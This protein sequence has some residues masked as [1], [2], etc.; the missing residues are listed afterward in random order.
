MKTYRLVVRPDI[1]LAAHGL[2]S[3][4]TEDALTQA[5]SD[6][7]LRELSEAH[8]GGQVVD[9]ALRRQDD[10]EALGEIVAALERLGFSLVEATVSE[11]ASGMAVKAMG[12][13]GGFVV[14]AGISENLVVGLILSAIGTFIGH[15]V[16]DAT[17]QVVGD[18]RAHR[19]HRGVWVFGEMV[20]R[21]PHVA[22]DWRLGTS[23][24]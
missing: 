5:I 18:Y 16:G 7:A 22:A 21:Q 20:P 9:V 15:L 1:R 19:D 24:A 11:W 23:P 10:A 13:A 4:L 14:G 3:P 12:A 17:R 6:I 8:F 2:L